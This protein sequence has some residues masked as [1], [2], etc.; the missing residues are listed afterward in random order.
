MA[1]EIFVTVGAAFYSPQISELTKTQAFSVSPVD[2][3]YFFSLVPVK[4]L[5][6]A[7]ARKFILVQCYPVR[8]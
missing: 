1:P 6:E 2:N 8:L 3:L 5:F 7:Y 4:L